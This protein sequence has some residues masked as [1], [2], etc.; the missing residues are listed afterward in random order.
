M[1]AMNRKVLNEV[2]AAYSDANGLEEIGI[3]PTLQF[4]ASEWVDKEEATQIMCEAL[5]CAPDIEGYNNFFPELLLRLPEDAKV[6]LARE[7]SVCVYFM[8][9][10]DLDDSFQDRMR[11]DEFDEIEYSEPPVYRLWWD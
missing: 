5:S 6:F 4:K 9:E 10:E 2:T 1:I 3:V 7:G 8:S 11:A